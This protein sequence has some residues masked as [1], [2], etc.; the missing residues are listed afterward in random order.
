M[1]EKVDVVQVLV[2]MVVLVLG[3]MVVEMVAYFL[4]YLA[5]LAI[6]LLVKF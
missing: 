3:D 4:A 5:H 6:L 1:V 2:Q